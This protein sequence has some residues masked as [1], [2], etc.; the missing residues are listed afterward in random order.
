MLNV[1][2]PYLAPEIALTDWINSHALT[3]KELRG[4][5]VIIDFWTY[6]CINCQR[7]LPYLVKW[8]KKYRDKG[9]VIIGVHAPEFSFEKKWENVENAVKDADISYPVVLDNDFSLWSAYNNHYWP[10]KYF[11]DKNGMVRH[12]HFGE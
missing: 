12:T 6:S 5:V 1:K 10:A 4:K 8:D 7:T 11:I 3:M 9:L 2:S